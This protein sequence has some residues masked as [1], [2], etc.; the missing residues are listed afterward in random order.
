MYPLASYMVLKVLGQERA[1][2]WEDER[3]QIPPAQRHHPITQSLALTLGHA[4]IAL[5]NRLEHFGQ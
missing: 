5:G 1:G 4:C 3:G 2:R